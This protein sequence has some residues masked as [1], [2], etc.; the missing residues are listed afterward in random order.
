[1]ASN[2]LWLVSSSTLT[3]CSSATVLPVAVGIQVSGTFSPSLE[4]ERLQFGSVLDN[5]SPLPRER[6]PVL[7]FRF[8]TGSVCS[9]WGD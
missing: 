4:T 9:V 6:A 3:R 5:L 2:S 7:H 8:A 1:M